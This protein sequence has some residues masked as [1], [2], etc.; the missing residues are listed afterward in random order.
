MWVS[1]SLEIFLIITCKCH[2]VDGVAVDSQYY[3]VIAF[4]FS[5]FL[6]ADAHI[7]NNNEILV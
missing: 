7:N 1:G 2:H 6:N 3:W 4:F 5:S